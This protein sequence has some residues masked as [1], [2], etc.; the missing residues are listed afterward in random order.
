MDIDGFL[1]LWVMEM[2]EVQ[3]TAGRDAWSRRKRG[4]L[5]CKD[6]SVKKCLPVCGIKWPLISIPLGWWFKYPKSGTHFVYQYMVIEI[7]RA[8]Y[9]KMP[10]NVFFFKMDN[11]D[12]HKLESKWNTPILRIKKKL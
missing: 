9:K 1:G 2:K 11:F 7:L 5:G 10:Q 12:S 3:K 6:N 4:T 8:W